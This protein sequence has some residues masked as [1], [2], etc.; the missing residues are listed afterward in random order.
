MLRRL[1]GPALLALAASAVLASAGLDARA[2]SA[3]ERPLRVFIRAGPNTNY[4]PGVHDHP[5]F[6]AEWKKLLAERGADVQGSLSF[7]SE[8]E[9]ARTDVLLVYA[10]DAGSIHGDERTRLEAWLAKGGGIVAIHD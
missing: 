5:R 2:A 1:S 8:A 10:Q 7:P 3:A 9:L 4:G 6:L